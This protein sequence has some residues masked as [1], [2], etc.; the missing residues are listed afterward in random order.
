MKKYTITILFCISALGGLFLFS[1]P[2]NAASYITGR[3]GQALSFDGSGDYIDMGDVSATVKTV[4]FWVSPNSTTEKFLELNG[5]AYIDATSGTVAA[6]GFTSPTIYVDGA[7]SSTLST[8]WHYVAVTTGTAIN[9]NSVIVG[10]IS[11]TYFTGSMDS[12]R[13]YN[14]ALSASEIANHYFSGRGKFDDYSA[15]IRL[16]ADDADSYLDEN[17]TLNQD[18]LLSYWYKVGQD[19]ANPINFTLSGSGTI[20]AE[21]NIMAS[22]TMGLVGAWNFEEGGSSATTADLSG[23]NN[24]GTLQAG[25]DTGSNDSA[26][27]MWTGGVS[28]KFGQAIEFDGTNDYVDINNPVLGATE[29]TVCAWVKKVGFVRYAG[30]VADYNT[31]GYKNFMLGYENPENTL[32]FYVG[33]GSNMDSIAKTGLTQDVWHYVCGVFIGSQTVSIYIDGAGSTEST[34]ITNIG[35]TQSASCDIGRYHGS[36][37]FNGLI[38]SVR[39]YNRV[40]TASEV[41]EHYKAGDWRQYEL[42]FEADQTGAHLFKFI[43]DGSTSGNSIV[44]VDNFRVDTNLT[45]DGD[46]ESFQGGNPDIPTSW[47]NDGLDSGEGVEGVEQ[48]HSGS[49]SLK[50]VAAD[51]DEGIYQ[52]VTV[53]SGKFYTLGIWAKNDN[54]DVDVVLSDAVSATVDLTTSNNNWTKFNYTLKSGG[55]TLRITIISGATDQTGYFDDVSLV[56]LD[57][58][59]TNTDPTTTT[60]SATANSYST[61]KWDGASKAFLLDGADDLEYNASGVLSTASGTVS[62]WWKPMWD[63]DAYDED[64]YIFNSEDG[65]NNFMRVYFD[66]SE[67]KIIANLYDGTNWTNVTATSSALTFAEDVWQHIGIIYGNDTGTVRI[68]LDGAESGTD[69][70]GSSWTEQTV[71]TYFYPGSLYGASANTNQADGWIDDIRIY[72]TAL[73]TSSLNDL[74][75]I[76]PNPPTNATWNRNLADPIIDG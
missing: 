74:Y 39:I 49:N 76:D 1:K 13:I 14:R 25:D 46:F 36:Y 9:A 38:D 51:A 70:D 30:I 50:L 64:A 23:N 28:G 29:M 60:P 16:M 6:T 63:Y 24:T 35:L 72:D 26:T 5:E 44:Y 55:T 75:T 65:T 7:E 57:S 17:L 18:Y 45:E 47:T 58:Y 8:G 59:S 61:G 22:S 68:L 56:E 2:A 19:N 3:F 71:P 66:A 31:E 73:A 11:T 10:K 41:Y 52:D 69:Y 42:S 20:V 21:E 15:K 12:I 34:S 43:Q 32:K 62:M 40:L 67:D 54:Q 33:D 48:I 53:E 4:S 37:E 27:D